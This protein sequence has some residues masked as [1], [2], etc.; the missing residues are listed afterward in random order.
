MSRTLIAQDRA[1]RN[2]AVTTTTKLAERILATAQVIRSR[3]PPGFTAV[4]PINILLE[5]YLAE[6]GASYL[7]GDELRCAA[8]TSPAVVRRWMLALEQQG[9][10]EA[11]QGL[12]ALSST[13]YE[14]VVAT[15]EEVFAV[16]RTLD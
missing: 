14:T 12:F 2:V 9:L 6:E 8:G 10:V 13:G 4:S 15:L 7:A 5:M 16:Q 1:V 3:M 11:R